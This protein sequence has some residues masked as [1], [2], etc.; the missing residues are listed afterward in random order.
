MMLLFWWVVIAAGFVLAAALLVW[1]PARNASREARFA[2][3]RRDFHVQ[4]ERLE[5]KFVQLASARSRPRAS[6]WDDCDFD[7]DVAYVRNRNTGE[8]SAFVA[9]TVEDD[10]LDDAPHT[11][12]DDIVSGLGESRRMG[13][14]IFRFDGDHW[15]TD[16]RAIPNLNP[17]DAI[18][19]YRD[20]LE[21]VDQELARQP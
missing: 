10:E 5:A 11:D 13:T 20:D 8:L 9:V 17:V 2:R 19:L 15:E 16:G 14:A 7:D 12:P 18:R 4:R 21:M 1:R 6:Y 3:A